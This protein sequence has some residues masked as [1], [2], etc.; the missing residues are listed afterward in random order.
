LQQNGLLSFFPGSRS[1]PLGPASNV[2]YGVG[3][4]AWVRESDRSHARAVRHHAGCE[5][6]VGRL[7]MAKKLH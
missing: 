7:E 3:H 4:L 2:H 6:E 5:G 1:A